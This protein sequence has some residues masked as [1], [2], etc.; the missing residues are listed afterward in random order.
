MNR[1]RS[2]FIAVCFVPP[3]VVGERERRLTE[4]VAARL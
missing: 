1:F 3:E 2:R 4:I